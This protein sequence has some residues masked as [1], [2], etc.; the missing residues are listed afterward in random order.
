MLK[1]PSTIP[2]SSIHEAPS[3]VYIHITQ[4][5]IQ[6]VYAWK[7]LGAFGK[8]LQQT[9]LKTYKYCISNHKVMC[10]MGVYAWKKSTT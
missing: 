9:L 4:F 3:H 8:G 10:T 7:L 1:A 5:K 2:A 6:Q